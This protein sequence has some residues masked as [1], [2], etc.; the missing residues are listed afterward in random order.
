VQWLP[1]DSRGLLFPAALGIAL[2]LAGIGEG[3]HG[4]GGA[5]ALVGLIPVALSLAR[6]GA[7]GAAVTAAVALAAVA[8]TVSVNAAVVV[9]LRYVLP[10]LAL[11]LVLSRRFSLPVALLV[12]GGVCLVGLLIL[13]WVYVPPGLSALALLD[14]QLD[15]RVSELEGLASRLPAVS[16]RAWLGESTRLMAEVVRIAGPA[17]ILVGLLIVALTNYVGAR[18]GLRGRPFRSFAEEAVPD[19][20]V[21][22]VIAGGA[23]VLSGH[24][25]AERI[26]LNLLLV[27][28]PLYAI[29]GLAVLRHF[30]V[31]AGVPRL[32]QGVSFGL[33]VVQPLL[34]VGAACLGLS[35]LWIDFRKIR[36]APTPA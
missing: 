9:G 6:A 15:R 11:G 32:L 13:V 12:V 21:W 19:H 33:F 7:R 14:R 25:T 22:A 17:V 34:L 20:L 8:G 30:F 36:R 1:R 29:Q 31:K 23:L 28:T 2:A 10:G 26:G 27:L 24:D 18:L 16:D 5:I 4:L 3:R 35:D